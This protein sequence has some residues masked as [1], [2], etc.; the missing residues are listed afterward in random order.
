MEA[1]GQIRLDVA[2]VDVISRRLSTSSEG[3]KIRYLDQVRQTDS[4]KLFL[5]HYTII[6]LE[7]AIESIPRV[8]PNRLDNLPPLALFVVVL[9]L[10]DI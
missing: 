8:E 2:R 6:A 3:T 9:S 4:A 5:V 1:L 7:S 10:C